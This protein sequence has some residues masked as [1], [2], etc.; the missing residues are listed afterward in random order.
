[1][2][3]PLNVLIVEDSEDD[4]L[5]MVEELREGGYDPAYERVET[6]DAL[7]A[8]LGARAWDI[9]LAD[10][11]L[12][13]F[14]GLDAIELVR[15]NTPDIPLIIVSGQIT[16]ETAVEAMKAG[17]RDYVLKDNLAR[18]APAIERELDEARQR[19]ERRKAEEER[20]RLAEQLR[21]LMDSTDQGI[22]G[23]DSDRRCT[24]IN[25]AAARVL[26][27]EPDEII[28][29]RT[30]E[31]F[32]HHH[33]DGSPFPAHECPVR[34][35]LETGEGVRVDED[36]LWRRDGTSFPAEYSAFPVRVDGE[37]TG[38]VVTLRDI[39]E[40][41]RAR[42]YL[43][44]YRLLS[45]SARDIILF[46]GLDGRILEANDAAIQ[47]YGYTREELLS[48]V[49]IVDLRAPEVRVPL[50]DQLAKADTHGI[51][52]ETIHLR[53]DGSKFPVE[54]SSRGETIGG[55]RMMLSII[56]DITLR[57]QAE[58]ALERAMDDVRLERDRMWA[59]GRVAEAGIST[60]D[61]H[62][63]LDLLARRVA[64]GMGTHSSHIMVLDESSGELVAQAVH[65]VPPEFVANVNPNKGFAGMIYRAGK[66]VYVREACD[67]PRITEPYLCR[68]EVRS[69]LGT[70]ITY[71][72]RF[73]GVLYVNTRE[74]R[75]F[76]WEDRGL[77]EA[78]AAA[79]ANALGNVRLYDELRH[80]RSELE[81][82][83][84]RERHFSLLL[85]R[86]LLPAE[87]EI[88]DGY[89]V[90]AEYVPV[91]ASR[92][93][94]G[95]FYDVFRVGD[96]MAGVLVGD[97][98]GKGLEAAS[99]AAT[100]RSTIHA[101]VHEAASP[102]EALAKAN[103]VLSSQQIAFGAFVTVFLAVI[104]LTTG[105]IS[106]SSAGHPPAAVCRSERRVE[107][108]EYGQVPL[109]VMGGQEFA[110]HSEQL[111]PGDKL[112]LYT[113]GISEAR[114]GTEFLDLEGIQRTLVE[115]WGLPATDLAQALIA[116][117][118]D[119]AE[120]KLADDA[121]IVVVERKAEGPPL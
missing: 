22:Y 47:A 98:S 17:A 33:A 28:G 42:G 94:S 16:E 96:H 93:I 51:L 58:E 30:H 59:M 2:S 75:E 21:L 68:A 6:R 64:E 70:P 110:E 8:R 65:D 114:R 25:R 36:T 106:Y 61:M 40:R 45:Q 19:Q 101:F 107:F 92:E 46:V 97:V 3:G 90:A 20:A 102:A 26:G 32:H 104:D 103:A 35:T 89:D 54:V 4:A 83:F 10:Y 7:A 99:L 117:A 108:L 41:K 14:S 121:A 73:L 27:Y 43:E 95:D 109:A 12:P 5:L 48:S 119:L 80:S 38:A 18:L 112:V 71:R 55:Q 56:R 78:M 15:Q 74:V 86:A 82:A 34:K 118:T 49:T 100:T 1:M 63:L 111:S 76:T 53:K 57:K 85:Q 79:V 50:A 37:V 62:E 88:G 11:R 60:L 31:L 87:P 105:E 9:V 29:K 67:D 91:Y 23:I 24:F 115:H 120:G 66:T 77:L 39:T 116:A 113:D 72:G 81:E 13:G 44:R 84:S 52:F 69:L